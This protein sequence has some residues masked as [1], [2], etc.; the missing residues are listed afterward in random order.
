MWL[1]ITNQLITPRLTFTKWWER[2]HNSLN[3]LFDF[4]FKTNFS[5][6][7]AAI[8][9][10][11]FTT[12]VW[13]YPVSFFRQVQIICGQ[14]IKFSTFTASEIN[15][16]RFREFKFFFCLFF[17]LKPVQWTVFRRKSIKR[18]F[19]SV[20]SLVQ[21]RFRDP[22]YWLSSEDGSL[23]EEKLNLWQ[24]STFKI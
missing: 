12:T 18:I 20:I 2:C 14:K 21:R 17:F 22:F 10:F 4:T 13:L 23:T 9:I 16:K 1:R 5:T 6:D 3:P 15:N 11:F 7:D 24:N 19:G 8:Y